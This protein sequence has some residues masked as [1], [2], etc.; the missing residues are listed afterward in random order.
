MWKGQVEGC[1]KQEAE[2]RR[3]KAEERKQGRGSREEEARERKQRV[4]AGRCV[5]KGTLPV[6]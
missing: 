2:G 4:E 5:Y 3:Q 1:R 6:Y